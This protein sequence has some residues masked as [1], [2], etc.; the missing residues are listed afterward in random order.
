MRVTE[1]AKRLGVSADWIRRL[2]RLGRI[3]PAARDV[4]GHRRYTSNNL[5]HLRGLILSGPRKRL[6]VERPVPEGMKR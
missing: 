1:A 3:P 6:M 5:T 4:N 2:E